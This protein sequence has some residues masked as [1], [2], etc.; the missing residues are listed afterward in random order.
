MYKVVVSNLYGSVVSDTVSLEL[1]GIPYDPQLIFSEEYI[2]LLASD[3]PG[4]SGNTTPEILDE[5]QNNISSEN[6]TGSLQIKSEE[7]EGIEWS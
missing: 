6:T 1:S 7:D 5:N 3:V 2:G 4:V